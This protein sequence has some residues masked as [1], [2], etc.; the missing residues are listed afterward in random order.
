MIARTVF[1]ALMVPC[2]PLV[3]LT[4]GSTIHGAEK[5]GA[6][7]KSVEI[8]A[9][10]SC[11]KDEK[12]TI[13]VVIKVRLG[14]S[15]KVTLKEKD[16]FFD[17]EIETKTIE[18]DPTDLTEWEQTVTFTFSPKKFERGKT[19]ELYAKAGDATSNVVKVRCK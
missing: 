9:P 7:V 5:A 12:L 11:S 14:W 13:K 10:D 1:I 4:T 2:M 18:H 3:A 6:F 8:I 15:I 19:L 16:L 17:D